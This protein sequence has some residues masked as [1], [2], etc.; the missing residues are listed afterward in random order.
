MSDVKDGGIVDLTSTKYLYHDET[1]L[2]YPTFTTFD[3]PHKEF[4]G[5]LRPQILYKRM[6][7][8]AFFFSMFWTYNTLRRIV[9]ETNRY[10]VEED[11]DGNVLPNWGGKNWRPLTLSKL[12]AFIIGICF[13][14][15]LRKQPNKKSYWLK[16]GSIFHYSIIT[17]LMS[18]DKFMDLTRCLHITNG[19][20]YVRD[21]NSSGYDKM[22][23]MRWLVDEVRENFRSYY[24]LGKFLTIDEL[25]IGYKGTYCPTL[26]YMPKKP[27]K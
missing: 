10:I 22:G 7:S 27:Q 8:L 21:R 11:E 12:K 17:K 14:M 25:M 26:R 13:Y 1:W 3:P 6:P 19:S 15:G 4:R 20:T 23:Q 9:V 24:N 2:Q 18:L 5:S 16:E